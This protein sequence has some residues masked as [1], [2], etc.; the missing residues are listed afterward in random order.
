MDTRRSGPRQE[1]SG[2]ETLVVLEWQ[3]RITRSRLRIVNSAGALSKWMGE[4]VQDWRGLGLLF[5]IS[6]AES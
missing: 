3:L 4:I 5:L 6:S 2:V 1:R